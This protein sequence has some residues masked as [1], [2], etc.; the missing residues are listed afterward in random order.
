MKMM[1]KIFAIFKELLY[2]SHNPSLLLT[3]LSIFNKASFTSL[4]LKLS[5]SVAHVT[6]EKKSLNS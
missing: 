6:C 1:M 5:A 4:R 3:L 2:I